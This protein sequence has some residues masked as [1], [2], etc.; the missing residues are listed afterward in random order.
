VDKRRS[1]VYGLPEEGAKLRSRRVVACELWREVNALALGQPAD[2]R[3]VVADEVRVRVVAPKRGNCVQEKGSGS[4]E[5]GRSLRVVVE[6]FAVEAR[7]AGMVVV[8]APRD[9]RENIPERA[10]R[11]VLSV[12]M[13]VPVPDA[14]AAFHG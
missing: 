5:A 3:R 4:E 6:A 12:D 11:V 14:L 13:D 10:V 1:P 7:R 9:L 8:L 2:Q